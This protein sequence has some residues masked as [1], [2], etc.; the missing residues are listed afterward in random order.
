LH[1][2]LKTHFKGDLTGGISSA[3]LSLPGS[4][5]Y[6][7]LVF[8][9]L[10]PEY[11]KT[12]IIAGLISYIIIN[13]VSSPLSGV[14]ILNS[15]PFSLSSFM[16][17]TALRS[18][19]EILKNNNI[20]DPNI[21][22]TMLFFLVALAGIIQIFFGLFRLGELTKYI[23]YPVI[24]GLFNGTA[25]MIFSRQINPMLGID[26]NIS[27]VD[28]SGAASQIQIFTLITGILTAITIWLANKF[29]K[30]FPAPIIGIAA[31]TLFYYF[32]SLINPNISLGPTIGFIPNTIPLPEY[33]SKIFS[34]FSGATGKIIQGNI[35]TFLALATG[36]AAII[37]LR[38][39]IASVT[40][41]SL[42]DDNSSTNRELVSQGIGNVV[43]S[44]FGGI[45]AAGSVSRTMGNYHYGGRTL[46]SRV[47]SGLSMLIILLFLNQILAIMPKVVLAGMLVYLSFFLIDKWSINLVF[48]AFEKNVSGKRETLVNLLVVIIVIISMLIFGIFH[49]VAIGFILSIFMFLQRMSK[50][51]IKRNF[52]AM[53]VRSNVQRP[54]YE[55]N[56]LDLHGSSIL[57]YELEGVLFFGTADRL[58]TIVSNSINNDHTIIILDFHHISEIDINGLSIIKKISKKCEDNNKTIFLSSISSR[59]ILEDFSSNN[60]DY[61]DSLDDALAKGE[62][63]VIRSHS[64]AETSINEMSIHEI[65]TLEHLSKGDHDILAPLMTRKVFTNDEYIFYE[66]AREDSVYFLVKGRA[67]IFIKDKTGCLKRVSTLSSGTVFGEMALIDGRPRSA[68][69]I[70]EGEVVCYVL[71]KENLDDLSKTCPEIS[72]AIYRGIGKEL[73]KRIRIAN[74]T[75]SVLR[76]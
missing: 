72:I 49:A 64:N 40:A 32:V 69:V 19:T 16:L 68:D 52:T 37:S 38:T 27:L 4:M 33:G 57:V 30:N 44:L 23:P 54:I 61:F 5:A 6:G 14:K 73:A 48:D 71:N 24:A 53:Q 7:S 60:I 59:H 35:L 2:Y 12:G 67:N 66:G 41:E 70:A 62:D 8:A 56:I 42:T 18:I 13:I 34:L 3:L 17:V 63:I 21:I 39:L 31:G 45:S 25:I 36:L 75:I 15:G 1:N 47:I 28:L 20:T 43:V 26:S 22:I 74:N 11:I 29:L 55:N 65:E 76:N 46:V 9:S 58:L 51:V 10:G 50:H